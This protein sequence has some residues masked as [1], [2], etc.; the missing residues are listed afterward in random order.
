MWPAWRESSMRFFS[1][2]IS[3]G[4]TVPSLFLHKQL[5]VTPLATPAGLPLF[6]QH[7]LQRIQVQRLLRH[8][9]LQSSVLFLHLT[10]PP[11]LVHFHSPV[12]RLP[13]VERGFTDTHPAAEVLH[14]NSG[15]RFF[16]HPDDLLFTKAAS[17]HGAS[18][19]AALYPEKLSF[20]WT[21]FRGAGHAHYRDI[22][23]MDVV[24][25]CEY[26]SKKYQ[27]ELT[28]AQGNILLSHL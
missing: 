21:K 9:P 18:P 10:Q 20:G 15:L 7:H 11:S 16:Q 19:L 5:D 8:D 26:V 25:L 17:F 12:L 28:L 22:L 1:G 24:S 6:C 4:K 3:S 27:A 14:G 13:V 23:K 2:S